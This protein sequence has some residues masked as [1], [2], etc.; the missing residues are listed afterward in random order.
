MVS[1]KIITVVGS[2]IAVTT[3]KNVVRPGRPLA[4]ESLRIDDPDAEA[5]E[6]G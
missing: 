6:S 2:A 3:L 4:S 1:P 5:V